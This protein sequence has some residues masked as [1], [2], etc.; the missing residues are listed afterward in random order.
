MRRLR[1]LARRIAEWSL[2][3][4][5]TPHDPCVSPASGY[6]S[7]AL[8]KYSSEGGPGPRYNMEE[9]PGSST[10]IRLIVHGYHLYPM[11]LFSEAGDKETRGMDLPPPSKQPGQSPLPPP[12]KYTPLPQPEYQWRPASEKTHLGLWYKVRGHGLGTRRMWRPL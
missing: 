9:V 8:V 5:G 10:L 6:V 7:L 2:D 4:G 1:S 12:F 3:L 11:P